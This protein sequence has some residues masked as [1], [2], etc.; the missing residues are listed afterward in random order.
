MTTIFTADWVLPITAPPIEHGAVVVQADQIL[1]VGPR[2]E[3]CAQFPHSAVQD[4]GAAVILPGFVNVHSHLE[5]TAFRGRLEEPHFQRWIATLIQLKSERL[6]SDDLLASA[7]LGCLE[8]IRAGVTTL[9]D[10]SDA[11][12]P[13]EAILESGLRGIIF[14]ECFGPRVE[15]SDESV[16]GVVVTVLVRTDHNVSVHGREVVWDVS[17][18]WINHH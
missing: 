1:A 3:L 4:F 14:Q 18:V 15:Q 12:A 7:R 17:S 2:L 8:A 6:T 9:A 10:T 5:L 13:L 11:S 16:Q